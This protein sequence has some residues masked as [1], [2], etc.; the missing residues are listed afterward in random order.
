[1]HLTSEWFE[2]LQEGILPATLVERL[3]LHHLAEG[4]PGL[5]RTVRGRRPPHEAPVF[6]RLT[7]LWNGGPLPARDLERA[8]RDRRDLLAFDRQERRLEAIH[9]AH[10]RFRSSTLVALLLEE[11]RERVAADP[12]SAFELA[13]LAAEVA[14]NGG[15]PSASGALSLALSW[16]GNALRAAGRLRAADPYLG[17]AWRLLEH[18]VDPPAWVEGEIASLQGSLLK[19]RRQ[20]AD[21]TSCLR[22]ALER[23]E[24][25]GDA[26]GRARVHLKLATVLRLD[27]R[28]ERAVEE[29]GRALRRGIS[30]HATPRLHAVALHNLVRYL[31]E[32]GEPRRARELFGVVDQLVHRFPEF[33]LRRM[34][35][36]GLV[37]RDAGEPGEAVRYLRRAVAGFVEDGA[38]FPAAFAALD[39][40]E[41]LVRQGRAAEVAAVTRPLPVLFRSQGVKPEARAAV[42]LFHRAATEHALTARL[43]PRLRRRLERAGG[44]PPRREL[45]DG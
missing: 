43:L 5:G 45:A 42:V 38:P 37:S 16:Q 31:S 21:A 44:A 2:Q 33:R 18:E 7:A 41:L 28:P 25:A 3:A 26:T 36:Q 19:D 1:M 13:E 39:L 6:L 32:A 24:R 27:G 10:T 23:F 20:L 29:V 8:R 4:R 17:K 9:R 40:A 34:W 35:L 22:F 30:P 11:A 12:R 14:R 15:A